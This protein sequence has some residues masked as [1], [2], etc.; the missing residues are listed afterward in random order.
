M[1]W[2]AGWR[3]AFV[4]QMFHPNGPSFLE[5]IRQALSSTQQ[6]YELLASK[7]DYT[8][9]RTPPELVDCL[10]PFIAETARSALDVCCG[11]GAGLELLLRQTDLKQITGI[12]FSPAMLAQARQNIGDTAEASSQHLDLIEGDVLEMHWPEP[13]DLAICLGALGHFDGEDYE[14]FLKRIFE[15]LKPGGSYLFAAGLQPTPRQ[16]VW[17]FCQAFNAAMRLRNL[18]I[19]PPFIMYYH[20]YMFVGPTL[21][22]LLKKVGFEVE[23]H[24]I[25]HSGVSDGLIHPNFRVIEAKRRGV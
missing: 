22:E 21:L 23:V 25:E 19:R 5:L 7:F 15:A 4:E 20:Q 16:G 24:E 13:F 3:Q 9:Y 8:P 12:D 10:E 6:G 1:N 11:T 2:R 18:V 17:W 14:T